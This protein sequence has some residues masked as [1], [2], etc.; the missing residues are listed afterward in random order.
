MIDAVAKAYESKRRFRRD[1]I[2]AVS[3]INATFSFAVR[4]GIRL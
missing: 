1:G 4:L 3:V 2:G